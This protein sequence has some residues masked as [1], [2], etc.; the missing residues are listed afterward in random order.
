[1]ENIIARIV[2]TIVTLVALGYGAYQ[3]RSLF[4]QS[5]VTTMTSDI[6]FV[7]NNA[8]GQFAQSANGY[9]NFTTDNAS[10]LQT[11]GVLPSDMMKAGTLTDAWGNAVTLD[12]TAGGSQAQITFGGGNGETA[13][14]CSQLVT[15]LHDYVSL[16]VGGSTT[17]SSSN[18][19]DGKTAAQACAGG[20]A[21]IT[22][23]FL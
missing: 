15:T 1:M 5:K 8:R 6:Q 20:T 19:P 11:A 9:T 13:D 4:N 12:S 7:I 22:L 3:S 14:Q 17:F 10:D 23:T 16:D 18:V 21:Q 2:A